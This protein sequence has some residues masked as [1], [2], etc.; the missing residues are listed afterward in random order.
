VTS[1]SPRSSL[2]ESTDQL[3]VS[4]RE[5]IE[6]QGDAHGAKTAL[7]VNDDPVTYAELNR[8]TNGI[9]NAFVELGLAPGDS[10]A[11]FCDNCLETVEYWLGA[12]KGGVVYG[13]VNSHYRGEFLRHPLA[14]ADAK[15]VL[16]ERELLPMLAAVA[17]DLPELRHVLIREDGSDRE[18]ALP[19][20]V[21]VA[22]AE[23]FCLQE[24]AS[25]DR[26][27]EA[28]PFETNQILFSAGTTGESKGVIASH[29]Y[30]L[31]SAEVCFRIKGG[32]SDDIQYTPLPL[33]H[34]N[35]M[36]QSV[37][38]PLIHGAKGCVDRKFSVT[39][40]WDRTRH[41][42]ATFATA[43]GSVIQMI[44][45]QPRRP[46][47]ADN[48]VRIWN[49]APMPAEIHRAFEER[50][51]LTYVS[52]YGLA[53][54]W[55][56]LLSSVDDPPEPGW[57][58]KKRDVFD[59]V[60]L[61]DDDCPVPDGEVGEF[62]CRPLAPSVMSN[63]YFRNPEATVEANRNLWFHTGDFG[64]RRA[65]G[66]FKFVDRKKDTV[67]R[68]G[69]NISSWEVEQAARRFDSVLEVAVFAVPS[70]V[71][72]DE[73]MVSVITSDP[74]EFDMTEFMDHCVVN[75]PYFAVPRYVD[76]VD[77]IPRSPTGK[78]LKTI[79]RERGVTSNTWDREKAGYVIDRRK[80]PT[81]S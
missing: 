78:P 41:F 73:L 21:H 62:A 35:A 66:W 19:P 16:T 24:S 14:L 76:L 34:G 61:D 29:R 79:L 39:R 2:V 52:T 55:P 48:P 27:Y 50:F 69:E 33:F 25:L 67:R 54:A 53:E 65:D 37:L 70:E 59:V 30:L 7:I 58:G 45:N 42:D 32:T 49:G 9:A 28:S 51:G 56:V 64:I 68:R 22:S 17:G 80:A 26:P 47:D 23:E 5:L 72:E 74:S 12:S 38:G 36:L 46:D 81:S 71:G 57:A 18:A 1:E 43:L 13:A 63:G 31:S 3:P 15:V 77:D 40:F 75:M 20:S 11:S 44:W 8:R 4:F 6:R 60:L 10:V